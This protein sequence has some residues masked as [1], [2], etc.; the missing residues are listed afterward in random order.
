MNVQ[1]VGS[2]ASLDSGIACPST[3]SFHQ[4]IHFSTPPVSELRN[5]LYNQVELRDEVLIS[6]FV[7]II[8]CDFRFDVRV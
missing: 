1:I 2:I 4:P 8:L 7:K 5:M 3:K 6:P